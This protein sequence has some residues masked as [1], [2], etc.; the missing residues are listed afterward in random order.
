MLTCKDQHECP[1]SHSIVVA[2]K[3]LS[4]FAAALALLIEAEQRMDIE[5]EAMQD[6]IT[7][8]CAEIAQLQKLLFKKNKRLLMYFE[9]SGESYIS[10]P[11]DQ[12]LLLSDSLSKFHT[13]ANSL[14][15][16]ME[17]RKELYEALE[18]NQQ[19]Y[20]KR[21]ALFS[22]SSRFNNDP[23]TTWLSIYCPFIERGK[24]AL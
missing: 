23:A 14:S 22:Y 8:I 16:T 6:L 4:T 17:E 13:V 24:P 15:L 20:K 9:Q 1:L 3:A 10:D 18:E 21:R 7:S 2:E 12:S 19:W 5:N 11:F